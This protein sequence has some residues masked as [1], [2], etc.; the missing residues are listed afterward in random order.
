LAHCGHPFVRYTIVELSATLRARQE[1]RLARFGARVRWLDA[2]PEEMRGVVLGNEVLDAMPVQLLQFD[3]QVWQE[4]GVAWQDGGF[5]F[6]D[7]LTTLKPPHEGP[8]LP[9]TVTE[10]HPQAEAFVRTL[11]GQ[12]KQGAAF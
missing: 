5:V 1:A 8:F 6:E 9:G 7:R 10:I 4:R 12:L 3:G 2:W 11:A